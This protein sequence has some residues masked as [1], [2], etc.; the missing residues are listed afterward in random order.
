MKF[1]RRITV[2]LLFCTLFLTALSLPASSSDDMGKEIALGEK[3][4][5]D[6]EKQWERV[7]DPALSARLSMLLVRFLPYLSRP[8]PYEVRIVREKMVNAFSLPGGIVY[9]TT[10]ML[11]FLRTDAEVAAILAHELIH[12][13][14]RH[15]M[16]QTARASKI[17]LA[18]LA[19]MIASQGSAGPM[20]LT[21][22]AQ[23][24]VTNSYSRDLEREADKEGFRILLEAGFPPAAMVTSLE[25]MIY[26]QMKRPYVD[27]GVFMTHPELSE[28]VAYI[29][30]TAKEAN[31]P[32]R[33]KK[34]LN[35]LRPSVE[36]GE[37]KTVLL[38][39]GEPVW[40]LPESSESRDIAAAAAEKIDDLLQME[41]AP[42]EIQIIS[43]D[44][45]NALRV[46]PSIVAREPLPRGA[47][48]LEAFRES[49]VR[50]LGNAHNKHPGAKYLH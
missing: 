8:L 43:L 47:E 11:D 24:A 45:K 49:L 30:Q 6:V 13:D 28:R 32:I 12:A 5:A 7:A 35:L 38:L 34:A 18:A 50:A 26:D 46:G 3:V 23:I 42:Y 16:I 37:G 15:V 17:N 1:C 4:A 14:K 9:F 10:G 25:A 20:I 44:G 27:P 48:S 33:R 21:N 22:L 19:L 41:T 39:D 40:S 36:S 29:L 31:V 2:V